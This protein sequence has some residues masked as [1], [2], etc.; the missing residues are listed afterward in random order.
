MSFNF[1]WSQLARIPLAEF[2]SSS[3]FSLTFLVNWARMFTSED[4][5]YQLLAGFGCFGAL[6]RKKY[7]ISITIS[8]D[9]ICNITILV[10][11]I[12][13]SSMSCPLVLY[14]EKSKVQPKIP[15]FRNFS[16]WLATLRNVSDIDGLR[17]RLG[18]KLLLELNLFH[19]APYAPYTHG[20]L[21]CLLYYS[22]L[23]QYTSAEYLRC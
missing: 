2:V 20:Q 16:R 8:E 18:V 11:R 6:N 23:Q 12:F 1:S 22:P 15:E 14:E 21:G 4:Q 10:V 9:A 17:C 7:F 19:H 3:F 5:C 13:L